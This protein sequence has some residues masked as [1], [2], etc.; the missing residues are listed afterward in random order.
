MDAID[1]Y[2]DCLARRHADKVEL[3]TIGRSYEGRAMRVVKIGR[4]GGSG[5]SKPAVW[6]DGGIHAREWISPASVMKMI[7]EFVENYQAHQG[8]LNTYDVYI[9]PVANPDG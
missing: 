4:G 3:I 5:G 7:F 2:L 6:I 1:R 8:I 9:L